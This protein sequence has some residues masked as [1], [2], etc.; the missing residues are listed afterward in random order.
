MP[1]TDRRSRRWSWHI[2]RVPLR[3]DQ[4]AALGDASRRQGRSLPRLV[5]DAVT[6][7]LDDGTGTARAA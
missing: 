4:I 3:L 6:S 5:S 2:V 1:A 7:F